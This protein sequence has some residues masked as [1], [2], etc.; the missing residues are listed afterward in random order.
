MSGD[1]KLTYV[2]M[3]TT[4]TSENLVLMQQRDKI[5]ITLSG[6][7][8]DNQK[9]TI[10]FGYGASEFVREDVN[11]NLVL[12]GV[13]GVNG[14]Y[15]QVTGTNAKTI[16]WSGMFYSKYA[17]QEKERLEQVICS[18]LPLT[19][20]AIYNSTP[21][22]VV[23]QSASFEIRKSCYITYNITLVEYN[24]IVFS[25]IKSD[26]WYGIPDNL[27]TNPE[28]ASEI[29]KNNCKEAVKFNCSGISGWAKW[30]TADY[31]HGKFNFINAPAKIGQLPGVDIAQQD[32]DLIACNA[33]IIVQDETRV[34]EFLQGVLNTLYLCFVAQ[35]IMGGYYMDNGKKV[36]LKSFNAF[37]CL[38]RSGTL[39][40][41]FMKFLISGC[42]YAYHTGFTGG[43]GYHEV[44]IALFE[45]SKVD[46]HICFSQTLIETIQQ[47]IRPLPGIIKSDFM[48]LIRGPKNTDNGYI[49]ISKQC[50]NAC[51]PGME[52]DSI[53]DS[54]SNSSGNSDSDEEKKKSGE[55][56][57]PEAEGIYFDALVWWGH[58]GLSIAAGAWNKDDKTHESDLTFDVMFTLYGPTT[59][60][61]TDRCRFIRDHICD[62]YPDTSALVPKTV[63]IATV[64]FTKPSTGT[65][66][67]TINLQVVKE[68][69]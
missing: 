26:Y 54:G 68:A 66:M 69:A 33:H 2:E 4:S 42:Y 15:V 39:N 67:K 49:E 14:A 58:D 53:G 48:L 28:Q 55:Q 11:Q 27:V 37:D 29:T 24:P 19:F 18:G 5:L 38:V 22:R 59:Q 16:T 3:P 63:Y 41:T 17:T 23:I 7:G 21:Y 6:A 43:T 47:H 65:L 36:L 46:G 13:A 30:F 52:D 8:I 62:W 32:Q 25:I 51:I 10:D 45:I 34:K 31:A 20:M 40:E 12:F 50:I 44:K 57:N 61:Y 56:N 64:S 9:G 1:N 60:T 35:L